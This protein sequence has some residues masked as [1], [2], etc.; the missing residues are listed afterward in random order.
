MSVIE[1]SSGAEV[2]EWCST[3]LMDAKK[4]FEIET[5][6]HKCFKDKR[7]KGEF[8]K[9]SFDEACAELQKHAEITFGTE[10]QLVA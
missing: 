2:V 9:I 8:F 1:H 3:D 5:A 4:A 10:K 7:L 6:C